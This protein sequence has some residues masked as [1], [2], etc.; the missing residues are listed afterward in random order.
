M[1][2]NTLKRDGLTYGCPPALGAKGT[3]LLK[4]VRICA[5]VKGIY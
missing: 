1:N 3:F 4:A 5:A 2:P